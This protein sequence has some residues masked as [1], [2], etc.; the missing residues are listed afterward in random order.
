VEEKK[1]RGEERRISVP[2]ER[3]RPPEYII[4]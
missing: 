1:G 4:R 3:Y 2:Q